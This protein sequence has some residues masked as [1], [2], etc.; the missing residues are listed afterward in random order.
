MSQSRGFENGLCSWGSSVAHTHR[1]GGLLKLR[2]T[3]GWNYESFNVTDQEEEMFPAGDV[4]RPW[5]SLT[6]SKNPF[7]YVVKCRQSDAGRMLSAAEKQL[8]S[9]DENLLAFAVRTHSLSGSC[10]EW[11][12]WGLCCG[13]LGIKTLLGGIWR[14]KKTWHCWADFYGLFFSPSLEKGRI[15]FCA[16]WKERT[17]S[18]PEEFS[19]NFWFLQCLIALWSPVLGEVQPFL[20]P[21]SL[22][23]WGF[24]CWEFLFPFKD[25]HLN[26]QIFPLSTFFREFV[27]RARKVQ[28]KKYYS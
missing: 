8:Y 23:S 27:M 6:Q 18:V 4:V 10:T 7:E 5:L 21:G 3:A 13:H 15:C 17:F 9:N 22:Q 26:W 25:K 14:K 19:G 2:N 28:S 16:R 11:A 24:T 20:P 12:R 1:A